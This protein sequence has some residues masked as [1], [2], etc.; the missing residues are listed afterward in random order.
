MLGSTQAVDS[1]TLTSTV[2]AL[3]ELVFWT[4]HTALRGF[5]RMCSGDGVQLK[6]N[7]NRTL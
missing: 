5:H 6:V 1:T 4:N 7:S 2:S 3:L